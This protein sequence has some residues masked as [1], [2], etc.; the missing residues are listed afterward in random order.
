MTPEKKTV[1]KEETEEVEEVETEEEDDDLDDV[2]EDE[3]W[4]RMGELI[5]KTVEEKLA[6]WQSNQG[7]TTSRNSPR[8]RAQP[9]RKKGFLSTGFFSNLDPDE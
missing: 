1:K 5:G 3:N 2:E 4:N 8:K 9:K 6:A 7:K